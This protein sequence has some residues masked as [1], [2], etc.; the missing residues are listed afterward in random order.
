MDPA[1]IRYELEFAYARATGGRPGPV[2]LEIPVDV[3]GAKIDPEKLEGYNRNPD[4][5][6]TEEIS[7]MVALVLDEIRKAKRPILVCGNGIHRANA[8]QLLRWVLER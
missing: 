5:D 1:K 8:Q 4:S 6:S 3:Q 7:R 2:Y